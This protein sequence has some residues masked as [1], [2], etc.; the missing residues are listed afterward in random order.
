[1]EYE[2]AVRSSAS[3]A[4]EIAA[5]SA[6]SGNESGDDGEFTLKAVTKPVKLALG[7]VVRTEEWAT[8]S[9]SRST[10]PWKRVA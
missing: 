3:V 10:C 5:T 2:G 7:S 8:P 4:A 9:A 6:H 1:M